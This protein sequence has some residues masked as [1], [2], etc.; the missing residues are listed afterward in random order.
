MAIAPSTVSPS[1]SVDASGRAL[2]LTDGEIRARAEAAIRTLDE[3]TAVTDESDTD[4]VWEQFSR[5]W[6]RTFNRPVRDGG[7]GP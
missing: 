5:G 3:I 7:P 4:E 2:P 1:R 6:S